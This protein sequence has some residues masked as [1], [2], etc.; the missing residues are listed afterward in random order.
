GNRYLWDPSEPVATRPLVW[1]HGGNTYSYTHD[2]TKNVS[3]VVDANGAVTAHYEYAPFGDVTVA[4]GNLASFNRFRFSSESADDTLGLVYYNYRHYE[5]VTGRWMSR[6]P[7]EEM[8]GRYLFIQNGIG[9]FIEFVG[10]MPIQR[11]RPSSS[12][13]SFQNFKSPVE[14][15][16]N[17]KKCRIDA[18]LYLSIIKPANWA[19]NDF[20]KFKE[21][22]SALTENYFSGLPWKCVSSDICCPCP[23]G[24]KVDFKVSYGANP[25]SLKVHLMK[26]PAN[27]HRSCTKSIIIAGTT[28]IDYINVDE[29]DLK[30]K[31]TIDEKTGQSYD[32]IPFIHEIG[33]VLG[34][35]HPGGKSNAM[36][37]YLADPESLMG[38]GMT[39]RPEDFES[40]FCKSGEF[41]QKVGSNGKCMDYKA[42]P[43][44]RQ[45]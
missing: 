38:V 43:L 2:G 4:A 45:K 24:F 7:V 37:A 13:P 27:I 11:T 22:A 40:A 39:M 6:D 28:Y 32:Q 12:P 23:Q 29:N 10:M 33:H 19:P 34:L 21:K 14:L 42:K 15:K 18:I 17:L 16:P 25:R 35:I 30:T 41:I 9:S 20:S 1:L 8:T 26:D 3:E 36:D 31:T 5:P 44:E